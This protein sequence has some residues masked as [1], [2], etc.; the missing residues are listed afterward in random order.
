[1]ALIARPLAKICLSAALVFFSLAWSAPGPAAA[2][3]LDRGPE[4]LGSY[5]VS[6]NDYNRQVNGF[7][8]GAMQFAIQSAFNF[9][10]GQWLQNMGW[11][12]LRNGFGQINLASYLPR[13]NDPAASNPVL[14]SKTWAEGFGKDLKGVFWEIMDRAGNYVR[15]G[16]ET[17]IRFFNRPTN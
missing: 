15:A 3:P 10:P 7:L 5:A 11:N 12:E 17:V 2:A 14:A 4:L 8:N 1:M 13:R 6:L 9:S 16:T